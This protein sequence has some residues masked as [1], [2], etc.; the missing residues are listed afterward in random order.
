MNATTP[1]VTAGAYEPTIPSEF[2]DCFERQRG[3]HLAHP[4]PD[5]EE[6]VRDLKAMHRLLVENRDRLVEAVNLDY[7]NRSRFETLFAECFLNQEGILDAIKHLRRWMKPQKRRL[8]IT[9]YPFARA[10]VIPQPVGVVG[11]VVPWNF[12]ISMAF[13]PLTGIIAAGNRAMVKMSENSNHLA[14]LL[15]EIS[16]KYLPEDKLKFFEDGNGRG[17]AFTSLPFDHI[18]FTGSPQT[19]KAVMASA[20]R[21]LTPVTLELGGKSPAVVAPDYSVQTAV[22]RI[23]WVKLL[24]AGQICTNVD[25]LFLQE[26]KVEDF[27][28]LARKVVNERYPDVNGNDYT[29]IIDER[30]YRRLETTLEDARRKGARLVNLVEGQ[31]PDRSLRKMPP[32]LVLNPTD[33]MEILQREIFGPLLPIRTYR[34][35]EE[36]AEYIKA[37]PRPL[38]F[39]VYTNDKSL[40]E[41]YIAHVMSGGV[42]VNDGLIHAGLHSLPF[43]GIGNSGMGHYHGVEGFTTFS[44]MRPVFYQGPIRLLNR[45]MPPYDR[46]A[47]KMLN[48]MLKLKS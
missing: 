48:F 26:D 23:M 42:T 32:H 16:T 37:R 15:M 20:A 45:M 33:D 30:S 35:R 36:V 38:A 11:I 43:G 3:A 4:L 13:A 2:I 31:K 22:E 41:W 29:S 8:D 25:Y 17:P 27:V 6:R 1:L 18:F 12:P 47:L 24:N 44:K 21:N 14:R 10:R 28:R 39:Y 19:G 7:G 34:T 9:Q 5:Y 46:G 40:Q